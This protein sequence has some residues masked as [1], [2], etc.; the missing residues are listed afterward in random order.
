MA[1]MQNMLDFP[2]APKLDPV[3]G[4]STRQGYPSEISGEKLFFG[5]PSRLPRAP[6]Y[7]TNQMHDCTS[8]AFSRTSPGTGHQGLHAARI[9][10]SPLPPRR[11]LSDAR[12]HRGVLRISCRRKL[13]AVEKRDLVAFMRQL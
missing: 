12:G 4:R 3:T 5:S 9:K 1:Q 10:E 11:A 2:P 7:L 8:S 13:T 6:F